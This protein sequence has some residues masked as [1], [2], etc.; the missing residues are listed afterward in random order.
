VL[1]CA[2]FAEPAHLPHLAALPVPIR[3]GTTVKTTRSFCLAASLA[4]LALTGGTLHAANREAAVVDNSADV[5]NELAGIALKGIPPSLIQDAQGVAI[6]P[7]MIKAGFVLGGRHGRGVIVVREPEGTWSNPIFITLTGGSIG[8]QVGI[9]A[10]DVVL[11]FKTRA[12]LDRVLQGKGK[13]TLGA[14][15]AVA[16][17]PL[18]RQVEA[19]TDAQLKAEI[20]SYSRSR[21]LF[22]GLAL[23]G[24]A[25]L[26]DDDSD[27][28]FYRL[29]NIRPKDIVAMKAMPVPGSV[30]RLQ[31]A[32]EKLGPPPAVPVQVPIP[33]PSSPP[34]LLPM[35]RP[36]PPSAPPPQ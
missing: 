12:S 33:T 27:E 21:G 35:P 13:F 31:E 22:A 6:I 20:Y 36:V 15:A 19:A 26:V 8:W 34:P 28:S 1:V 11:V 16:A 3:K 24:A 5:L 29:Q 25:L 18:G 30:V 2:S 32:L 14:D 10:T 17:G 9:Q 23:E 7:N 4:V